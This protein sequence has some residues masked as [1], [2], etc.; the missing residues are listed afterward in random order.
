MSD[1]FQ[2][3][4]SCFGIVRSPAFVRQPEGTDVAERDIRTLTE[5]VLWVRH[6][7]TVEEP[8]QVLAAACAPVSAAPHAAYRAAQVPAPVAAQHA[9]SATGCAMSSAPETGQS[10]FAAMAD[11]VAPLRADPETDLKA[12]DL[13]PDF[14]QSIES[15]R[16]GQ[17]PLLGSP[18][19][20]LAIRALGG[21]S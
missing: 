7:A 11:N 10:G 15:I 5:P 8:R 16:L 12:A 19:V 20:D 1:A 2:N 4:T 13:C 18:R 17:K 14:G 3:E 9:F 21:V 6:C